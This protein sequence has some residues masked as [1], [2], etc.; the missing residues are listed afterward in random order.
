MFDEASSI[1]DLVW[2]VAEG[3][4]T[5][6]RTEII[7]LCLGNPTLSTGRFC[8][9]FGRLRH[10]W[11]SLQV[12]SRTVEGTNKTQLA[13]WIEDYGEDSDFVRVRVRGEFPR[14]G[15]SQLIPPD[16]V[17]RARRTKAEGFDGSAHNHGL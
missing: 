9:C 4:L 17:A 12:D 5:D 6:E 2:E 10:R 16:L 15:S 14:S 8:E 13:Q 1:I 3:A 11:N 7:W